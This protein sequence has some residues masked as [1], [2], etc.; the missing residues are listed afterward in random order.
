MSGCNKYLKKFTVL[1]LMIA[2][3]VIVD[4]FFIQGVINL[5][6]STSIPTE[7]I[8]PGKKI[9]TYK[10]YPFNEYTGEKPAFPNEREWIFSHPMGIGNYFKIISVEIPNPEDYAEAQYQ[11]V[12]DFS[13]GYNQSIFW[14]KME[15]VEGRFIFKTKRVCPFLQL[16]LKTRDRIRKIPS[17]I[18]VRIE[19]QAP[20][21]LLGI[22]GIDAENIL[23]KGDRAADASEFISLGPHFFERPVRTVKIDTSFDTY[24]SINILNGLNCNIIGEINFENLNLSEAMES[25]KYYGD[26]VRIWKLTGT[27]KTT[28]DSAET[29]AR[30][31]CNN[32]SSSIILWENEGLLSDVESGFA[33]KEWSP[34][35][36]NR[37]T[38]W[39]GVIM[40]SLLFLIIGT[41][42]IF[43]L[44][45]K[46]EFIN[47]NRYLKFI[48]A[49]AVVFLLPLAT[50]GLN[51]SISLYLLK[52][53]GLGFISVFLIEFVRC[54][55]LSGIESILNLNMK[56][57]KKRNLPIKLYSIIFLSAL[58]TSFLFAGYPG[59]SSAGSLLLILS[60]F[61]AGLFLSYLFVKENSLTLNVIVHFIS[62]LA[63]FIMIGK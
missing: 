9:Y 40:F 14:E 53:V 13:D 26:M 20:I 62:V 16:R 22:S 60:N 19:S 32:S 52:I 30:S 27:A 49:L 44:G 3:T 7:E 11:T 47:I 56:I 2:A 50:E 41:I 36:L 59:F 28:R 24:R 6:S 58:L 21:G 25:I 23:I 63:F 4:R 12:F 1:V 31:I 15:Y 33:E 34:V 45:I 55:F 18:V 54:F 5:P 39:T 48:P 61:I 8:A 35:K 29:I 57:Y 10:F 42:K 38:L 46:I 51:I 43:K 17:S 37:G